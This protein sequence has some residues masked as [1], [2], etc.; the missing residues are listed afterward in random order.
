M[1]ATI[2]TV[3]Q[4]GKNYTKLNI[5]E[6]E[7]GQLSFLTHVGR[8]NHVIWDVPKLKKLSDAQRSVRLAAHQGACLFVDGDY[9]VRM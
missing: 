7:K 1:K 3:R 6:F 9:F 8:W 4:A 5:S 2:A